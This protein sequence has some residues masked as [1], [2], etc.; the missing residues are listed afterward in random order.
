METQT[1]ITATKGLVEEFIRR[2]FNEH[3]AAATPEYFS[4][5]VQWHG[6]TLGTIE[7][8]E[9]MTSFYGDL[10]AHAVRWQGDIYLEDGLHRAVRSALRNRHVIHA[11]LLDLDNVS[12]LTREPSTGVESVS[13]PTGHGP[14]HQPADVHGWSEPGTIRPVR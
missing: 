13:P 9:A 12:E 1:T 10:F 11:R 4:P 8:A 3:N 2:V 6:G 7:G 14:R 5:D